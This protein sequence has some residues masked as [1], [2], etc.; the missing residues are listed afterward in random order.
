MRIF[1]A[2]L[3]VS[4]AADEAAESRPS[5]VRFDIDDRSVSDPDRRIDLTVPDALYMIDT[6]TPEYRPERIELTCPNGTRMWLDAW[7]AAQRSIY[8]FDVS[9]SDNER[10][11]LSAGTVTGSVLPTPVGPA[12]CE[13]CTYD[14]FVCTDGATVCTA[15]CS[16]AHE[17]DLCT[18]DAAAGP[19]DP[20]APSGYSWPPE[21]P[22]DTDP[23]WTDPLPDPEPD[24]G[25]GGTT[26]GSSG[27]SS[28]GSSS[29]SGSGAPGNANGTNTLPL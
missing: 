12:S 25:S 18:L 20:W 13:D 27:G 23:P 5:V 10:F 26:G 7:I 8:G 21:D 2:I 9:R 19:N 28:S 1:C 24:G 11:F 14:C 15:T 22:D 17:A 29:G 6:S 16:P 4:C 3:L